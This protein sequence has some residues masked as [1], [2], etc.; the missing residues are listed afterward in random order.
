M[1]CSRSKTSWSSRNCGKRRCGAKGIAPVSNAIRRQTVCA[2][3]TLRST[4][5]FVVAAYGEATKAIGFTFMFIF[6]SVL[7]RGVSRGPPDRTDRREAGERGVKRVRTVSEALDFHPVVEK[8]NCDLFAGRSVGLRH[9]DRRRTFGVDEADCLHKR[10]HVV[11]PAFRAGCGRDHGDDLGT[12][13]RLTGA[14]CEPGHERLRLGEVVV[15][16]RRIDVDASGPRRDEPV[17]L[18][19]IALTRGANCR[20]EV[21]AWVEIDLPSEEL[22]HDL[23]EARRGAKQWIRNGHGFLLSC[24]STRRLSRPSLQS[25]ER[26]KS[27]KARRSLKR[28]SFPAAECFGSGRSCRFLHSCSEI[29]APLPPRNGQKKRSCACS[30][31]KSATAEGGTPGTAGSRSPT[32]RRRTGSRSPAGAP[33]RAPPSLLR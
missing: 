3:F 1:P 11:T 13:V 25:P 2:N 30:A 16:P 21:R 26:Q 22:A 5:S 29:V 6:L 10:E 14:L 23:D 9:E 24:T 18:G 20:G 19:S 27:S 15:T 17:A 28:C 4:S 8:G 33:S 7:L 12:V 32:T 31:R